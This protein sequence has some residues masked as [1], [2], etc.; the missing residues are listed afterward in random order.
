MKQYSYK[1]SILLSMQDYK[2]IHFGLKIPV[3]INYEKNVCEQT[4]LIF[5]QADVLRPA[6]AV[7]T[8]PGLKY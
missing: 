2:A 7:R 8:A 5:N 3:L 1:A 6:H 4:R